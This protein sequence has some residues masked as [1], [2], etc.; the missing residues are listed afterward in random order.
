MSKFL[1]TKTHFLE[2]CFYFSRHFWFKSCHT[3]FYLFR[4]IFFKWILAGVIK[5]KKKRVFYMLVFC[6]RFSLCSWSE[7]TILNNPGFIRKGR[8]KK[9]KRAWN[10][11][12]GSIFKYVKEKKS[13]WPW[14]RDLRAEHLR[15]SA[16]KIKCPLPSD[17]L[18]YNLWE[19]RVGL[20][21]HLAPG[22]HEI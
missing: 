3:F 18:L 9:K 10:Y 8:K 21:L 7:R 20:K 14:L 1:N 2:L 19:G 6:E 17:D 22:C 12:Y 16:W 13:I 4:K 15:K 11:Q 5:G